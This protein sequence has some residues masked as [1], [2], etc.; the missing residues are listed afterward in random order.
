[1]TL[2]MQ[3]Q[4]Y[5]HLNIERDKAING[6]EPTIYNFIP[7]VD[8]FTTGHEHADI[9]NFIIAAGEDVLAIDPAFYG[10]KNLDNHNINKGR[11]HNVITIDGAGPDWDDETEWADLNKTPDGYKMSYKGNYWNY[12]LGIRTSKKAI[13]TRDIKVVQVKDSLSYYEIDDYVR[14]KN[15]WDDENVRF[16]LNGNGSSNDGSFYQLNTNTAVWNYPCMKD[17]NRSDNWKMQ[18]TTTTFV[19][20]VSTETDIIPV[21]GYKH[22]NFNTVFNPTLSSNTFLTKASNITNFETTTG[23]ARGEHTR[24]A[25]ELTIAANET[26]HFKTTIRMFRCNDRDTIIPQIQRTQ[27]YTSHLLKFNAIDSLRHFHLS[28]IDKSTSLDSVINPFNLSTNLLLKTNAQNVFFSYSLNKNQSLG[29]C[30]ANT[31]FRTASIENGDSLFYN[32]TAYIAANKKCEAYYTLIGKYKYQGYIQCDSVD[33]VSFYLDD[34]DTNFVMG[35]NGKGITYTYDTASHIITL[36]APVGYTPFIIQLA[37]PCVMNCYFPTEMDSVTNT[38]DFN[39]GIPE[40]LPYKLTITPPNGLL[41]IRNGSKMQI[42][43]QKWLHNND[44][45]IMEGPCPAIATRP[46]FVTCTSTIGG[47]PTTNI[48]IM[49]FNDKSEIIISDYAALILDSGSYTRFGNNTKLVVMPNGS[50]IIRKNAIVHIG[51]EKGCGYAQII[52]HPNSY[53][54]FEDSADIQFWKIENDT[55]DIH[56]FYISVVPQT[57]ATHAGIEPNMANMLA[58]VDYIP[59]GTAAPICNVKQI[60]A[61]Y[62]IN[63]RDWGFANFAL[64]KAWAYISQDTFCPGQ[65]PDINFDRMLNDTRRTI[66]FCKIDTNFNVNPPQ[67]I[68]DTCINPFVPGYFNT[69]YPDM[70]DTLK[71]I[72]P[73][74]FC[75]PL[76][77]QPGKWYRITIIVYNDCGQMDSMNLYYYNQPALNPAFELAQIGCPNNIKA[78]EYASANNLR[79]KTRWHVHIVDTNETNVLAPKIQY[80][81]DW[82][83]DYQNYPD[84]FTFP[85]FKWIGGFIYAVSHTISTHRCGDTTVWDSIIIIPGAKIK[86][87]RPTAYALP[88]STN[89]SI[90]LNGYTSTADSFTWSPNTWLNR[91]DTLSV[92]STPTDVLPTC[93][94]PIK[95]AAPPPILPT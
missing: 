95:T 55:N 19:N 47:R 49:D 91:T 32:D 84:T 13:V 39:T 76:L 81:A 15:W 38:F 88:I 31:N 1:M 6:G 94:L 57:T 41:K 69:P 70:C 83:Y 30:I 12:N 66:K 29:C 20:D 8:A 21:D 18:V 11:H 7:F 17:G 85:N 71:P 45:L 65:C 78:F 48:D 61:G 73:L 42:C 58:N 50:L 86:L 87:S 46:S 63:N 2:P 92:I 54:Q 53:V 52:C 68:F 25:K 40:T 28:R 90:Q 43:P 35:A 9:G 14:N 37:D 80:G 44:S 4:H 74:S 23:Y 77:T 34:M 3:N 62:G 60:R 72:P 27:K 89:N 22:G 5:I 93:L 10:D 67:A 75:D 33:S 16:N 36:I 26:A 56:V 59:V 51:D 24:M 64:P 79:Q 82:E